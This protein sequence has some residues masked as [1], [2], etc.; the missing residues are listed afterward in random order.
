MCR[1]NSYSDWLKGFTDYNIH[2]FHGRYAV[3]DPGI[4][5]LLEARVSVS[6]Q[7]GP[8]AHPAYYT[9][10]TEYFS[11]AKRPER[12]V[13]HPFPYSAEAANGLEL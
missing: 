5:I 3:D 1:I 7:I 2:K 8:E 11:G 9:M 6:L 12:G 10:G 4:E 13:D